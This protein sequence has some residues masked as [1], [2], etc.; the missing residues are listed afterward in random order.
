M[1]ILIGTGVYCKMSEKDNL[2]YRL[3]SDK[4]II[5]RREFLGTSSRALAGMLGLSAALPLVGCGEDTEEELPTLPEEILKSKIVFQRPNGLDNDIWIVNADG[6][7][8]TKAE[9]SGYGASSNILFSPD[10]SL[11][12]YANKDYKFI[13]CDL[14]GKLVDLVGEPNV[15]HLSAGDVSWIPDSHSLLFGS[16]MEGI[17]R[18]DIEEGKVTRIL[19]T[20]GE[21]YDHNPSISPDK[22]RIAYVHHE[23]GD[24]YTICVID[25]DGGNKKEISGG[26]GTDHDEKIN[27]CWL[28]NSKIVFKIRPLGELHVLD[29]DTK[30]EKVIDISPYYEKISLSPDRQTIALYHGAAIKNLCFVDM[31]NIMNEPVNINDT[32]INSSMGFAWSRDNNYFVISETYPYDT[33]QIFDRNLQ[34]Y[35]FKLEERLPEDGVAYILR[36]DWGPLPDSIDSPQPRLDPL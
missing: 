23:W 13:V 24:L 32:G 29:V 21:T 30:E 22:K 18:Y 16:Y 9:N 25:A 19:F 27:I 35:K 6:S 3:G 4:R 11:I 12:V 14:E 28:D 34:Q 7:N 17:Y 33:L 5:G 10:G 2:I 15:G 26:A 1:L 36:M 8:L 31:R 20:Q